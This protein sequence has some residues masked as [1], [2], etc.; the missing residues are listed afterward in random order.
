MR[1]RKLT[2]GHAVLSS[3]LCCV[4]HCPLMMSMCQLCSEKLNREFSLFLSTCIRMLS[5]CCAWC[6]KW[7]LWK[8]PPLK[9]LR[10]MSGSRKSCRNICSHL[11]LNRL[12][13]TNPDYVFSYNILYYSDVKLAANSVM[14][15]QN[16]TAILLSIFHLGQWRDPFVQ[17]PFSLWL[18]SRTDVLW[19]CLQRE[20]ES[21]TPL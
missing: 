1:A 14:N 10:N 4:V 20:L 17:S 13:L 3:M 16:E 2:S 19:P 11:P 6:C 7:T 15:Q 5:A 8:E 12:L 9:M 18:M 21:L